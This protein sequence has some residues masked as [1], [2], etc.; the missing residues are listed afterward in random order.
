WSREWVS[1]LDTSKLPPIPSASTLPQIPS[2][3]HLIVDYSQTGYC[4]NVHAG[5]D[6]ETTRTNLA[7]YAL[8]VKHRVS[9]NSPMGIGLWLSANAAANLARAEP[10]LDF[11]HEWFAH[12]G[13][14]P[15]TLNG[16]PY[17]DFHQSV[18]KHRV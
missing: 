4:T 17:G 14:V 2:R 18:V 12:N 11:S 5:D 9:P 1:S 6:I 3:R 8:A 15:Y 13:L 16:F 10:T 7:K